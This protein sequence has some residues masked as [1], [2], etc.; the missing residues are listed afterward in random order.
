MRSF[1]D[2]IKI[3]DL[4]PGWL[5]HI[6]ARNST[7]GIWLPQ[8]NSF[9]ISRIKFTANY[10]FEEFHW[11]TGAPFGT[12]KPIEEVELAPFDYTTLNERWKDI[13][14]EKTKN[15]IGYPNGKEVL[16]YL[17]TFKNLEKEE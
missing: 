6:D 9:L 15:Y 11:D 10:L 16:A 4:K 7:H 5:Y 1:V 14:G 13:P 17:N 8:R 3:P 2:Y 12:V